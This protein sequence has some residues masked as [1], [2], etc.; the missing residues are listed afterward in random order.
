MNTLAVISF[1]TFDLLCTCIYIG[2]NRDL[3][4][5]A[6]AMVKLWQ[7]NAIAK[8]AIKRGVLNTLNEKMAEE[9]KVNS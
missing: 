4:G 2:R 3:Q 1:F 6:Q 5:L 8:I 9:L 7:T